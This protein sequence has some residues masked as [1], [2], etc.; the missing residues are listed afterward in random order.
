M[1]I[2]ATAS[3]GLIAAFGTMTKPL[4]AAR[5]AADGVMAAFLAERGFS[6][7]TSL[8]ESPHQF[9]ETFTGVT[10]DHPEEIGR[11]WG[12]PYMLTR[13]SFKMHAS[14]MAT[15]GAIDAA[16]LLGQQLVA[17]AVTPERIAHVHAKVNPLV[18]GVAGIVLPSSGLEAKFSVTACIALGLLDGRATPDCF[19]DDRIARSDLQALIYRTP[20]PLNRDRVVLGQS[21]DEVGALNQYVRSRISG[22]GLRNEVQT[23][24]TNSKIRR[25]RKPAQQKTR[26]SG[27][28]VFSIE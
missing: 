20:E 13:N 19:M 27:S 7:P 9:S 4:Q 18:L 8:F 17:A 16:I 28:D 25:F 3:S 15:H 12:A 2:A 22:F 23:R 5:P 1:G 21:G 6:G 11:N 26:R 24:R 10:F 14:C